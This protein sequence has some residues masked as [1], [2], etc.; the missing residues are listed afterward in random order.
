VFS[1]LQIYQN[2]CALLGEYTLKKGKWLTG[3]KYSKTRVWAK[4]APQAQAILPGWSYADGIVGSTAKMS[5][6]YLEQF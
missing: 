2:K 3:R 5:D 6:G 1:L 4:A